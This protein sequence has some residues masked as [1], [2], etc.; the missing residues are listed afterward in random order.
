MHPQNSITRAVEGKDSSGWCT[1]GKTKKD[2][3]SNGEFSKKKRNE[4]K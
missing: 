4:K 2:L 1:T 3:G